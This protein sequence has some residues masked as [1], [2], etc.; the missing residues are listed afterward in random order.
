MRHRGNYEKLPSDDEFQ[1]DKS[2]KKKTTTNFLPEQ[3]TKRERPIPWKS[4]AYAAIL[5]IVG[6]ALLLMGCLIRTGHIDNQRYADRLWPLIFFGSIL[7]IP[8]SYHV[9]LAVQTF[10]GVYG[11]SFDDFPA[12]D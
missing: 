1:E 3:F 10:R 11:Y 12:F 6:T 8:G 9:F 2:R 7:F 5:F 4:I